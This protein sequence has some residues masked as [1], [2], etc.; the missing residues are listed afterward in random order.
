MRLDELTTVTPES[1]AECL[2]LIR[3]AVVETGLF[4]PITEKPTV[5]F[6]GTNGGANWGGGSLNPETNTLFVNSMDVG[7]F[8]RLVKRPEGARIPYRNQS[9]GRFW[10]S[11]QYPCQEPPWGTLT[12]IDLNRGEIRWQVRLGEFDELRARGI[13]PTGPPNLG[14]SIATKGGL[15][16]IGATN[17]RRFRAYDQETGRELWTARLPASAHA[18]P[19]TYLGPRSGRQFVM[20]AAGGGNRYNSGA[21]AKLIAF[22]LAR[23]GDPAQPELISAAERPA[24]QPAGP[25]ETAAGNPKPRMRSDYQRKVEQLPRKIADQPVPFNHR[26]HRST[27]CASCHPTAATAARAGL[28][29][30]PGCLTCHDQ[31]LADHP[32]IGLLRQFAASKTRVPWVRA[33]QLPDF[34]YFEHDRHGNQG[35]ACSEC[36]GPVSERDVIAQEVSTSMAACLNCHR[37][38]QASLQCNL[39][40]D[41]GQ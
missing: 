19:M 7:A 32:A 2:Q 28:P 22:A 3:D 38:R 5:M 35:I 10:D 34:V 1:R 29:D 39:C 26:L 9:F 30:A 31:L 23:D 12:A 20:I 37:E 25:G 27:P 40:H 16:F 6:P 14:G 15:I 36:H 24:A 41:L 13:P 33:Y 4:P 11:K 18:T 21:D 17:D 8:L